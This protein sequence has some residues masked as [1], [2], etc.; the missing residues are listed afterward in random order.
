M[1][2]WVQREFG[3]SRVS[4]TLVNGTSIPYPQLKI[5]C[6]SICNGQHL[7]AIERAVQRAWSQGY[8]GLV[9]LDRRVLHVWLSKILFGIVVRET[10]L[11]RERSDPLDPATVLPAEELERY[12]TLHALMQWA[13]LPDLRVDF[14]PWSIFVFRTRVHQE[15]AAS[16]DLADDIDRLLISMRLGPVAVVAS[17][18]DNGLHQ[19][20]L[21]PLYAKTEG[22][23]LHP[24]QI[25]EFFA[26]LLYS[27]A[28][29]QRFPKYVIIESATEVQVVDLPI[30]GFSLKPV[31]AEPNVED[32]LP[33]LSAFSNHPMSFLSEQLP[34]VPTWLT[35]E[36]GAFFEV[37]D[38]SYSNR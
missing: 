6:C 3:L 17:L 35:D 4:L 10:M 23:A 16:F 29:M 25:R 38:P 7:S 20:R 33:I 30:M 31:F 2:K 37:Q 11:K 22:Q 24:I 32:Y 34:R 5:P 14:Q 15:P 27:S 18:L 26:Q 1:P 13:R 36:D 28:L 9:R 8:D 21:L 19:E 12:F